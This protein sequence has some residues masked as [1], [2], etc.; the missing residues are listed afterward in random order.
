[1]EECTIV[2]ASPQTGNPKWTW[3]YSLIQYR[4]QGERYS[5]IHEALGKSNDHV[6]RVAVPAKTLWLNCNQVGTGETG[7]GSTIYHMP[8]GSVAGA[9]WWTIPWYPDAPIFDQSNLPGP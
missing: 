9:Q 3:R 1:M 7:V 4:V 8:P 5:L 2:Y 6:D